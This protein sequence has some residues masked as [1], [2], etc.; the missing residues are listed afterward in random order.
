[1]VRLSLIVRCLF[2]LVVFTVSALVTTRLPLLAEGGMPLRIRCAARGGF[3]R[4]APSIVEVTITNLATPIP[5]PTGEAS[6]WSVED[7][8][9]DSQQR[10]YSV[11]YFNER[12]VTPPYSLEVRNSEGSIVQAVERPGVFAYR[13][14]SD[15]GV[16]RRVALPPGR[17]ETFRADVRR[18][19]CALPAGSYSAAFVYFP[20]IAPSPGYRC[21][22]TL[23]FTLEGP[24]ITPERIFDWGGD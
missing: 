14:L 7:R 5:R 16:R 10:N 4:V 17:T 24:P 20:S 12:T 9:K 6:T 3:S 19:I 15:P 21:E 2:L 8:S 23:E 22:D 13:L 1:M 18:M 11:R